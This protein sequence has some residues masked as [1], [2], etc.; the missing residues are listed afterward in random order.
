MPSRARHDTGPFC[1]RALFLLQQDTMPFWMGKKGPFSSIILRLAFCLCALSCFRRRI[2]TA[3]ERA[4]HT[5]LVNDTIASACPR[6]WLLSVN[7]APTVLARLG[8]KG[9]TQLERADL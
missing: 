1:D 3:R 9:Q 4:Q 2:S 6:C 5:D 7:C 8:E